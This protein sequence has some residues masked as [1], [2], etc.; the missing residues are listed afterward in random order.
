MI[1]E[2]RLIRHALALGK[3]GNFARAAEALHLTQP[4]LSRSI[5]A[6]EQALDVPLFDRAPRSVT[7]TPFG[8]VLL[9][10]GENLLSSEAELRREI[11][12]LA[13]LEAGSLAIGAGPYASE[14][15]VAT[16]IARVLKAHPR[17]KIRCATADPAEVVH[18]VLAERI[19]VGIAEISG[20]DDDKRLIVETLPSHRIVLACR[21]GHPLATEIQ[22]SLARVN[23]FPLVTTL[24]RGAAAATASERGSGVANGGDS[25]DFVPPISVNSL[26]LARRIAR[27]SDALFPS[28][29]GMIADDLAA[30]FLAV[31]DF[32]A[33]VMRTNYGVIYLAGRTLAPSARVFIKALH[34]V[35][36]EAR[37]ADSQPPSQ[38]PSVTRSAPQG[39]LRPC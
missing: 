10:R 30:G 25:E 33:P 13:G 39:A 29:V 7:P 4:S 23:A 38:P 34:A 19:D 8:R 1:I 5:A 17:L 21:P 11:R 36:A 2:L 31:V 16:A 28:T 32:A 14:I 22:P 20:A 24:L 27:D 9:E 15:S 6:L 35:E 3:H 26:A 12:R 37:Q 18:D